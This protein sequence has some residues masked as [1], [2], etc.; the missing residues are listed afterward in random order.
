MTGDRTLQS[1]G[2]RFVEAG[3]VAA[4]FGDK[5]DFG[6]GVTVAYTASTDSYKLTAPDRTT[7]V[8]FTPADAFPST[9]TNTLEWSKH[10]G[11]DRDDLFLTIPTVNGVTLSYTIIGTW[12][13]FDGLKA[14]TLRRVIIGGAPTL[15]SDMP[16]TGTATYATFVGGTGSRAGTLYALDPS[17]VTF[18]ADFANNAVT[19]ALTMAGKPLAGGS[20]ITTFGTFNG[21]GTI[22]STG[23]G[24]AGTFAGTGVTDSGF[25]GAFFGPKALEMAYAWF[26]NGTNF[27]GGGIV[28]GAKQ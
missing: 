25:S 1:A 18:S 13:H 16:R 6:K 24:F 20:T 15:A 3:N 23:S 8:N 7:T 17:S 2:V 14:E 10:T 11:G 21:T 9:E 5:F 27:T 19:T 4:A 26:I 22:S 28:A 12:S